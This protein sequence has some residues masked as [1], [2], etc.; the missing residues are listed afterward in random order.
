VAE[1]ARLWFRKLSCKATAWGWVRQPFAPRPGK[2]CSRNR[3][4]GRLNIALFFTEGNEGHEGVFHLRLLCSLL[5]EDCFTVARPTFNSCGH[6]SPEGGFFLAGI[7][8]FK[9]NSKAGYGKENPF[10]LPCQKL[11]HWLR[12][13][14]RLIAPNAPKSGG[15]RSKRTRDT[16][17]MST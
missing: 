3:F 14:D 4:D 5:C 2:R 13:R 8:L 11:G 17:D 6:D 12:S 15:A 9:Y 7:A 1:A 10:G 16:L